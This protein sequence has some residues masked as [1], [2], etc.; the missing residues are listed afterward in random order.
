M[1][2]EAAKLALFR[3]DLQDVRRML[4]NIP[5]YMICDDHEVTDDWNMTR[6]TCKS[7]YGHPLGLRVAQNAL[8]AYS[9]CQHWGNVPEV[10]EGER[11]AGREGLARPARRHARR[12]AATKRTRPRCA[13]WSACTTS[14]RSPRGR[15]T[16]C[17]TT[18]IR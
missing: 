2:R 3:K 6:D 15:T 8:V 1:T 14:P 9:L 16:L 18:R 10:F 5:S 12:G 7:L 17:S 11:G 4:A 13:R